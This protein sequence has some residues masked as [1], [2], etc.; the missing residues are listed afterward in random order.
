VNEEP[1][2]LLHQSYSSY[3]LNKEEEK[4]GAVNK[5]RA[6]IAQVLLGLDLSHVKLG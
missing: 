1:P 5:R 3:T 6:V 4:E 2:S